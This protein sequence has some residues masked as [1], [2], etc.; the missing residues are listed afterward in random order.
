MPGR[1][2]PGG[3]GRRGLPATLAQRLPVL[4]PDR[5]QQ[6]AGAATSVGLVGGLC[7]GR[8]LAGPAACPAGR[9]VGPLAAAGERVAAGETA[10]AWLAA[11]GAGVRDR[12]RADDPFR[13][14]HR[15]ACRRD[16]AW[17]LGPWR[18]VFCP[19][20]YSWSPC[21]STWPGVSGLARPRLPT[22]RPPVPRAG[23]AAVSR[24]LVRAHTPGLRRP[25]CR[26]A[27]LGCRNATRVLLLLGI[28]S[29]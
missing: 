28:T 3:R 2:R 13:G 26:T 10:G 16:V 22:A 15:A 8:R 12:R 18:Q 5:P 27:Y 14:R 17:H 23:C 25:P 1:R 24:V 29:P 21:P 20:R 4:R 6:A 9:E 19:W 7:G 11:A